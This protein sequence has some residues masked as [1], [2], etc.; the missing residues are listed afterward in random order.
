M[1]TS[2]IL[3]I[4]ENHSKVGQTAD[5]YEHWVRVDESF[6]WG[7]IMFPIIWYIKQNVSRKKLLI[8]CSTFYCLLK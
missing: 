6:V 4:Q 2:I 1:Y 5:I 7:F 3:W 8:H